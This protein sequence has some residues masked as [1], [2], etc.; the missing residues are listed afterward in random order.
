MD[1]DGDEWMDD[2]WRRISENDPNTDALEE[3]GDE[4]YYI[5]TMTDENWEQLG[6]DIAN[7]T[8]LTHVDLHGDAL[9]DRKMACFFRG[10]TRSS[11]IKEMALCRNH[12][13]VAAVRSMVPFLQNANNL[14][15]LQLS[16]SNLQSEGFNVL[17][18]AL[19][20]SPIEMLYCCH[21]GIESI[22]IDNENKPKHLKELSLH[23]NNIDA[24]GCREAA[25]LLQGGDA[26]LESLNIS[27]N[28]INDEGVEIL[29]EALQSNTSMTIINLT[30]NDGITSREN[31]VAEASE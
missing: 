10:L 18:Q 2:L 15:C 14:T 19:R 12:L 4:N 8:H 13:S 7:N 21:C 28:N 29:V 5:Q 25:K 22:E 1:D 24:D 20:Y 11:S 9:N 16:D 3:D 23:D 27:R 30:R 26:T 6:H 17:F 31:H